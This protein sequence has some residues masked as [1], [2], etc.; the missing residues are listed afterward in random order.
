MQILKVFIL[1]STERRN[2]ETAVSF[3]E[4]VAADGK[5]CYVHCK[6]GR[7]RSA[8]IAACYLMKKYNYMPNV[9]LSTIKL[10]RPQVCY[11]SFAKLGFKVINPFLGGPKGSPL[12]DAEWI[13]SLF[14]QRYT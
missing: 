7:T 6:A 3:M 12:E 10:N 5:T 13:S 11:H 1:C 2:V 14:G 4:E 8:T 9:A